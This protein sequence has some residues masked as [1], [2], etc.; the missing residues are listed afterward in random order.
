MEF[1]KIIL[2]DKHH[3]TFLIVIVLDKDSDMIAQSLHLSILA[4]LAAL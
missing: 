1:I 3:L 2:M 4:V